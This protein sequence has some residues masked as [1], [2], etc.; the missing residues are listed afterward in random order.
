VAGLLARY[1]PRIEL[2]ALIA[3]HL[4]AAARG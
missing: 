3:P 4:A 1:R 2:H